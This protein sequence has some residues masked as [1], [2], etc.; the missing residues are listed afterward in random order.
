VPFV[1]VVR[2]EFDAHRVWFS[3]GA[4]NIPGAVFEILSQTFGFDLVLVSLII[5]SARVHC[6]YGLVA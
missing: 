2:N 6:L 1:L 5:F 3:S 4:K